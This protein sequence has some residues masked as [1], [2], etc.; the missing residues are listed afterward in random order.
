MALATKCDRCG[1]YF[2]DDEKVQFRCGS[3]N[4]IRLFDMDRFNPN[5]GI[6]RKLYDL[7]PKCLIELRTWLDG[8]E[9]KTN[10]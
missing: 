3:V 8:E 6:G 4:A 1:V 10:D 9:K 2:G 7:C 5:R